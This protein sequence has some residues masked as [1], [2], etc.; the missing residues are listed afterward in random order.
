MTEPRA[1]EK[2]KIT[3]DQPAPS[4]NDDA[5]SPAERIE[6]DV[7]EP[8]QDHRLLKLACRRIAGARERQGARVFDRERTGPPFGND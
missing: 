4:G 3:P 8:R 7:A 2:S 5:L 1:W 6:I